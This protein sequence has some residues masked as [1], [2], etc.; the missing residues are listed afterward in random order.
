MENEEK[1]LAQA[2][3][4]GDQDAFQ[5]LVSTHQ[6]RL[7]GIA[8]SYLHSEADALDALQETV[9]RGWMKCGSLRQPE[10]LVPWL[11]RILINYCRDELKRRKKYQPLHGSVEGG[12]AEMISDRKLDLQHA[13]AH[14]KPKYREVLI[15]KYYQDMTIAE[16]AQ[17]LEKPEGTIKTW[18]Y[19]G[20]KQMKLRLD[21]GGEMQHG[22]A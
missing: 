11:I 13:L 7:Y 6:R 8:Y 16:I 5:R 18:L 21:T 10:I 3:C 2:A 1:R 19:K 22:G 9:C 17:V 12:S 20:L 4:K 15:L 14:M